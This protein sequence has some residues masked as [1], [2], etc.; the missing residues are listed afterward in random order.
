MYRYMFVT[1]RLALVKVLIKG[2]AS[3]YKGV[4]FLSAYGILWLELPNG[5]SRPTLKALCSFVRVSN[6]IGATP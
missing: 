6:I 2:H 5:K 1:K 4:F 3:V